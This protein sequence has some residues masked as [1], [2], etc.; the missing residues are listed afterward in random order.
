M[1]VPNSESWEQCLEVCACIERAALGGKLASFPGLPHLQLLI[2]SSMHTGSDQKPVE[3]H[4]NEARASTSRL[5]IWWDN[6]HELYS[7]AIARN[8]YY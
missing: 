6:L 7:N 4:G 3:G 1:S 5:S 2:A 8:N